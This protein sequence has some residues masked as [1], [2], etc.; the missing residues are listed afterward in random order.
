MDHITESDVRIVKVVPNPS[1]L[2]IS[3]RQNQGSIKCSEYGCSYVAQ[4]PSLLGWHK[5]KI[6]KTRTA[7]EKNTE[8][9]YHC[10]VPECVFNSQSFR[11]FKSLDIVRTHYMKLH[12]PKQ[13]QCLQCSKTFGL[14]RDFQRHTKECGQTFT[15]IDCGKNY[16]NKAALIKHCDYNR[17]KRPNFNVGDKVAKEK[18]LPKKVN[19]LKLSPSYQKSP[20]FILPKPLPVVLTIP[21]LNHCSLEIQTESIAA[22]FYVSKMSSQHSVSQSVQTNSISTSTKTAG[23]QTNAQTR[24]LSI[25]LQ[26]MGTKP[27][28][29]VCAVQTQTGDSI[30]QGAMM[31]ASIPVLKLSKST[32]KSGSKRTRERKPKNK[33]R[34]SQGTI[35]N[36]DSASSKVT[37]AR[38]KKS[39]LEDYV[40]SMATQ[41]NLSCIPQD[42]LSQ[43]TDCHTQTNTYSYLISQRQVNRPTDQVTQ[44][45]MYDSSM[46]QVTQTA[47]NISFLEKN[48]VGHVPFQD[49]QTQTVQELSDME[50]S[51]RESVLTPDQLLMSLLEESSQNTLPSPDCIQN[52]ETHRSVSII[53]PELTT[54]HINENSQPITSDDNLEVLSPYDQT[55]LLSQLLNSVQWESSAALSS[56]CY[57]NNAVSMETQTFESLAM[58][59]MTQTIEDLAWDI[60]TQTVEDIVSDTM[61]QTGDDLL[62]YLT[63]DTQTQTL[64]EFFDQL[65]Y[66][67]DICNSVTKS[68]NTSLSSIFENQDSSP[69]NNP[70]ITLGDN[71][72]TQTIWDTQPIELH[73]ICVEPWR[74]PSSCAEDD[75]LTLSPQLDCMLGSSPQAFLKETEHSETQTLFDPFF[76]LHESLANHRRNFESSHTQT[77]FDIDPVLP[78]IALDLDALQCSPQNVRMETSETQ[79]AFDLDL[80]ITRE[81]QTPWDD[82]ITTESSET[83]TL[84]TDLTFL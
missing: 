63:S 17:H 7:H 10:P 84:E 69:K 77:N 71:V 37:K 24:T 75:T 14:E 62:E 39:E 19:K 70:D 27:A 48:G 82:F 43:F 28:E 74:S 78:S 32:Q 46:D 29:N 36:F 73:D 58:D 67:S 20:A 38:E 61:T 8:Y 79:T 55:N 21:A 60:G 59:S 2:Q 16:Y 51:C 30:L 31:V 1:E 47:N 68:L 42:L 65:T 52:N 66:P 76:T 12:S 53:E 45:K 18:C 23:I 64:D 3:N 34:Q 5:T 26:T 13:F 44:T 25:A 40:G 35:A 54:A 15:C 33:P 6:H 22:Q 41:T 9:Q 81:C 57:A 83:Q 72:G 11:Y 56:S 50:E 49:I 4:S 80:S